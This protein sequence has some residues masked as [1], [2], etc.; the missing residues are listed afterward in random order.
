MNNCPQ[1][2]EKK[3]TVVINENLS[4]EDIMIVQMSKKSQNLETVIPTE[5]ED[6]NETFFRNVEYRVSRSDLNISFSLPTPTMDTASKVSFIKESCIPF[7]AI[8]SVVK[9]KY[10]YYGLNRSP[11]IIKGLVRL[12]INIDGNIQ[13]E[14][15][16]FVVPNM[17]KYCSIVLGR[18]AITRFGFRLTKPNDELIDEAIDEILNIDSDLLNADK[19]PQINDQVSYDIQGQIRQLF[20]NHYINPSRS[21]KPKIDET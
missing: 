6:D 13:R 20:K 2:K 5:N 21:N 4:E 1:I 7:K 9:V 15:E 19:L 18:Q 14:V 12:D 16:V 3:Q 11:L 10:H 8:E 17:T